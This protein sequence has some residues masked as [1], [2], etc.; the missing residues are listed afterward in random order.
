MKLKEFIETFIE[1]YSLIRLWYK[2]QDTDGYSKIDMV[3]PYSIQRA[4]ELIESEFANR[5]VIGVTSILI[6]QSPY[7]ET[8]NII[9]ERQ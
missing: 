4:Q 5:E 3:T 7:P 8:V 9:I 1:P 6:T 2:T